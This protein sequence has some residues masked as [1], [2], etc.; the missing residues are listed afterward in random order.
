MTDK[1]WEGAGF[2]TEPLPCPI[3]SPGL[4]PA[5]VGVPWEQPVLPEAMQSQGHRL[6]VHVGSL[7]TRCMGQSEQ[8]PLGS[9]FYAPCRGAQA[10][11]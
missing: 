10:P 5:L 9:S 2:C 8:L 6:G 11:E 3:A 4:A 7:P 1:A